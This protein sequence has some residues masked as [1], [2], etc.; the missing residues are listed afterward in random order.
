MQQASEKDFKKISREVAN[1]PRL[2]F[3]HRWVRLGSTNIKVEAVACLRIRGWWCPFFGDFH[4][5]FT[6]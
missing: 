5:F 4:F 6:F 3:V 2:A 1:A